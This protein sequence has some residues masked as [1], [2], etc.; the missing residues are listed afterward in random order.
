M[1]TWRGGVSESDIPLCFLHVLNVLNV[2]LVLGFSSSVDDD[3]SYETEEADQYSYEPHPDGENDMFLF[4]GL[5]FSI[6][7]FFLVM[8]FNHYQCSL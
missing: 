7:R 8:S 6:F 4:K 1:L 3:L 5:G 2:G